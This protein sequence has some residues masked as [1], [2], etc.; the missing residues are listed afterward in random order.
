MALFND[1]PINRIE[2][3]ASHDSSLLE[4]STIEGIDVT[5]KIANAQDAIGTEILTFLLDNNP[6]DPVFGDTL[7]CRR[8]TL[9]VTDVV[10]TAELKRWHAFRTLHGVYED[11]CGRQSNDRYQWKW[12]Q[13]GAL[14]R[15]AKAGCLG[16]G[17]GLAADPI[18]R[19][20]APLVTTVPGAGAAATFYF[21]V[22][23][24]N[25]AGLEGVASEV[26]MANVAATMQAQVQLSARPDNARGWNVYAGSAPG[27]LMRQNDEV[28]EVSASWTQPGLPRAGSEPGDGQPVILHAVQNRVIR[29]G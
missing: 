2:E 25:A 10:V 12:Q 8:R 1:G 24:V 22:T 20:Q 26:V 28:L 23:L 15:T 27:S 11:A 21:A 4:T 18:P 9:G 14:A 7:S 16:V 17:I 13:Y 29:R 6:A 19:A 5:A 3:L